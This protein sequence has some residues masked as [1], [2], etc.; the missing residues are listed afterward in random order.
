LDVSVMVE[1]DV[2]VWAIATAA[3]KLADKTNVDTTF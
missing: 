2:V 3:I 1:L